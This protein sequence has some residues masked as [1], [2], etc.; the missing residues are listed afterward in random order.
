MLMSR[1]NA[2][3][4]RGHGITPHTLRPALAIR[5]DQEVAA[6]GDIPAM[7][8]HMSTRIRPQMWPKMWAHLRSQMRWHTY[9]TKTSGR[10]DAPA[11][12]LAG[13]YSGIVPP[14]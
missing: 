3:F 4:G 8:G 11:S 10:G 13:Q 1:C 7:L 6:L 9:L 5:T 14:G 2:V 12:R